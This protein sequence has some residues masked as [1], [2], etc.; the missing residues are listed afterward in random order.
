M[1]T[2]LY[3]YII[4][5]EWYNVFL[6]MIEVCDHF[7][8]YWDSFQV[9]TAENLSHSVDVICLHGLHLKINHLPGTNICFTKSGLRI[10]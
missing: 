6:I 9:S 3:G 2:G 5:Y 10:R 7:V 1:F 4:A 8:Q